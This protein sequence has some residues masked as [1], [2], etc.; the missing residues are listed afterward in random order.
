MKYAANRLMTLIGCVI[1]L[2][3]IG[4]GTAMAQDQP[5][6]KASV[7]IGAVKATPSML[8]AA[9]RANTLT[10][11]K[12]VIEAMDGQLMD[13]LQNTRKFTL[14]SRSDLPEILKE[15]G[16][17]AS[18]NIDSDDTQAAAAFKL[19]GCKYLVVTTVDSFQDYVEKAQFKAM[20]E[21]ATRRVVQFS[22]VAKMYDTT[23][24][25]LLESANFQL[26]NGEVERNAGYVK[27]HG[28][29]NDEL[30]TQMARLMSQEIA[31]RVI[32]LIYPAKIIAKSDRV[33]TINRGDGT[34][35][36]VG[37]VWEAFLLGDELKDPDT[38]ASLGREETRVGKVRITEVDPMF[39]KGE[40]MDD[41][42]VDRGQIVRP[43]LAPPQQQGSPPGGPQGPGQAPPGQPGGQ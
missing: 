33:V 36:A 22:A 38:G 35:I 5:T 31:D 19:A 10:Q 29:L 28:D 7:G 40:V 14:V 32:D 4:T 34:S 20:G 24:G 13:R 21:S 17:T 15:Q 42:G 39:S 16:L 27:Q 43:L 26:N 1:V 37:Q 25:K 12:R 8:E 23:T 11:M 2:A 3:M 41:H 9:Q 18:G 6:G 30:F